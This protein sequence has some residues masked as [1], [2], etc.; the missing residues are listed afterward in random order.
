VDSLKS[1]KGAIDK[2]VQQAVSDLRD[3]VEQAGSDGR[4]ALSD[5]TSFLKTKGEQGVDVLKSLISTGAGIAFEAGCTA[6][7]DMAAAA[8]AFNGAARKAIETLSEKANLGIDAARA[9]ISRFVDTLAN[10]AGQA[11]AQ[12]RG[13]FQAML[14]Q[15]GVVADLVKAKAM[16]CKQAVEAL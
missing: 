3:A 10:R 2:T 14:Q 5:L 6:L 12:V 13:D 9:Q 16:D 11:E 1:G 7:G 4:K 15:G 8:G